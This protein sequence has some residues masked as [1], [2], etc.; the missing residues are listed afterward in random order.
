[1][2]NTITY[3]RPQDKNSKPTL[4]RD[5]ATINDIKAENEDKKNKCHICPK[6][7]CLWL[8]HFGSGF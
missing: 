1:M 4:H 2:K 8:K 7:A 3:P 6:V 5:I